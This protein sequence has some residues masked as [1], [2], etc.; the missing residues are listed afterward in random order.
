LT[1]KDLYG[2]FKHLWNPKD[3]IPKPGVAGSIPAG[4]TIS[5]IFESAATLQ[6]A[7]I[8]IQIQRILTLV[9]KPCPLKKTILD[10]DNM[11]CL[12]QEQKKK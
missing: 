1:V 4:G 6:S 2:I 12:V 10:Q 8:L 5:L 3:K 7:N 9:L 11:L